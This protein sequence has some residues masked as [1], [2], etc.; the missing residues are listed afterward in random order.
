MPARF[1]TPSMTSLA[2]SAAALAVLGSGTFLATS[3]ETLLRTSFST[4]LGT[5]VAAPQRVAKTVPLA[6][7][8]EY[9]LSAM[10]AGSG[11][12]VTKA[13]AIGDR[14]SMRLGGEE[15]TLE[16]AS[17]AEF[18]PKFTEIDTTPGPSRFV[19]VTAKDMAKDKDMAKGT[20]NTP[21]RPIRFVMEIEAAPA[22]I[23]AGQPAQSL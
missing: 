14:I 11:A 17:V 15:R 4:A 13:V 22:Q 12:P 19:L 20:G 18:T 2:A 6:G 1:S 8:E 16:V 5:S 21:A 7:S 23:V 3:S 9:W 10:R